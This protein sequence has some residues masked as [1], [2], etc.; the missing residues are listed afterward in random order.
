VNTKQVF[1]DPYGTLY[2]I[3]STVHNFESIEDQM[4]NGEKE[5]RKLVEDTFHKLDE[6]EKRKQLKIREQFKVKEERKLKI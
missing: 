6:K 1:V 5:L 2:L 4:S 3:G